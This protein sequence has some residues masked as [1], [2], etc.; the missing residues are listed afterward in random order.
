MGVV[1][2]GSPVFLDDPHEAEAVELE[3]RWEFPL[4]GR[5]LNPPF[6]AIAILH[7]YGERLSGSGREPL[8]DGG[9][10]GP[11]LCH[12]F[13]YEAEL[14]LAFEADIEEV[15]QS[16]HGFLGQ[17]G[18]I[19]ALDG[20]PVIPWAEGILLNPHS[21]WSGWSGILAE[22]SLSSPDISSS[23]GSGMKT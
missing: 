9:S 18:G 10:G 22:Y 12:A 15:H 11:C 6:H 13:A 8:N 19:G 7:H 17:A 2:Y 21:G 3:Y 16:Q 20:H 14:A 5:W 1:A 4:D 23:T